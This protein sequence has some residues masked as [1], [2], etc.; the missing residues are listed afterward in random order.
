[1]KKESSNLRLL[2]VNVLLALAWPNHQFH[3]AVVRA[4][5]RNRNRW[6]TCALTQLGFIRLSSNPVALPGAKSPAEC[7]ALLEVMV[8]DPS[9]VYLNRLPPAAGHPSFA[10]LLGH[11]QVTDAYLLLLAR[12]HNAIFVTFDTRLRSLASKDQQVEILS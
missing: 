5:Q 7:A 8:S 4:M 11:N 6:A 2:D 9:H 1:M 12:R 10:R 3:A